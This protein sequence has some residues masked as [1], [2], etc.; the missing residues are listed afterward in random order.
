MNASTHPGRLGLAFA[1]LTLFAVGAAP[2][3]RSG[4]IVAISGSDGTTN[5][6]WTDIKNDTYDLRA[7]FSAG[8]N[9]LS[10][11]LNEQIRVLRAKRA[12]MTTDLKDWDLAMKEVDDSRS[13]LTSRITELNKTTTPEAWVDAKDKVGEAWQRSQLAVDKMNTTVTN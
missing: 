13:L 10:S 6:A 11:R 9:R 8:A 2:T 12:L 3:A 5:P 1:L 4:D 7:H